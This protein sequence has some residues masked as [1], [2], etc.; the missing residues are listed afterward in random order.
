MEAAMGRNIQKAK[1]GLLGTG[2]VSE[3]HRRLSPCVVLLA[4]TG[5]SWLLLCP[6]SL[7]N[8][9]SWGCEGTGV[10]GSRVSAGSMAFMPITSPRLSFVQCP[11][12]G[13]L[14]S[15]VSRETEEKAGVSWVM[16][17]NA[18]RFDVV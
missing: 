13:V 15:L 11:I 17:E 4:E 1:H 9:P 7:G 10:G 6:Q 16:D 3:S 14:L 12:F 8:S 5:P 2:Q 18:F